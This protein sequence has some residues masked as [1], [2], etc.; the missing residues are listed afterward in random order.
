M[1]ISVIIPHLDLPGT[2]DVLRTCFKSIEKA[3]ENIELIIVLGII[4]YGKAV[5]EGLE[6]A[7]GDYLFVVNN[8]TEL[9]SG[10]LRYMIY[11]DHITVPQITPSSRD[12][13]P[14]CFF[15]VPRKIYEEVKNF[16]SEDFY[17]ERFFPGYFEDD[18]LIH[19]LEL[20]GRKT[21]LVS[22]VIVRHKDGG[23]LTM[24]QLGEQESFDSNK[25]KY[26]EKWNN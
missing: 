22:N 13:N 21:L 25:I 14:R 1:K 3:D 7:T 11:P 4:G 24:K 23:G 18:D 16:H 10:K 20:L 8:D 9:L 26:E 15:C 19:R 6:R 17:D 12:N 5:N 2:N